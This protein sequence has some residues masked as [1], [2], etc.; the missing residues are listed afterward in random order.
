MGTH[1][2]AY[3][4]ARGVP[5]HVHELQGAYAQ[6]RPAMP[7]GYQLVVEGDRAFI[8]F[9]TAAVAPVL[10]TPARA[11]GA[12]WAVIGV[13][14]FVVLAVTAV[15]LAFVLAPA[16]P[17]SSAPPPGQYGPVNSSLLGINVGDCVRLTTTDW[18]DPLQE[19]N[20][21]RA[22]CGRAANVHSVTS[23]H[24]SITREQALDNVYLCAEN[25]DGKR[26]A[27]WA[28]RNNLFGTI[29][30]FGAAQG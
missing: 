3:D 6:W 26:L 20:A 21:T 8:I 11:S 28:S 27:V 29:V 10:P 9:P 4:V 15:A 23:T 2:H 22:K 19:I 25:P 13:V 16:A 24:D 12:R 14:G 7:A 17:S 5:V 30:C 18:T 1:W